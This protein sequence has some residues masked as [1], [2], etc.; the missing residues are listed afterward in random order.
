MND[1]LKTHCTAWALDELGD[2]DRVTLEQTLR[3]D[4]E[5]RTY[6]EETKDFCALLSTTLATAPDTALTE[7][8]RSGLTVAFSSEAAAP[9]PKVA[10]FRLAPVAWMVGLGGAAAALAVWSSQQAPFAKQPTVAANDSRAARE[11]LGERFGKDSR[12][13]DEVVVRAKESDALGVATDAPAVS[14]PMAEAEPASAP[15]VDDLKTDANVAAAAKEPVPELRQSGLNRMQAEAA[16]ASQPAYKELP[17]EASKPLAG[18]IE[19]AQ[20][21][22]DLAPAAAPPPPMPTTPMPARGLGRGDAGLGGMG[23]GGLEKSRAGVH[24]ADGEAGEGRYR[25]VEEPKAQ[26][27]GDDARRRT[28]PATRTAELYEEL[29]ENPF[30]AVAAAP[31]STFSID[32]DTASYANVRRFLNQGQRPPKAAVRTEELVNYFTYD[33]PQPEAGKPFSVT[34]DMTEAPWQPKHRLARIGLKGRE[35]PAAERPACNLV[36]LLDVSG[37]MDE[38]D[39][40]PLVKQ[41]LR[42]VTGQLTERDRVSLVTY[43][44]ESGVA[45]PSTPA[46]DKARITA[47]I[48]ALRAG[49][50]TNGASGIRLAYDQAAAHFTKEGVNRVIIATDGDFNVG[51]TSR[52]ALQQLITEQAKRGIFL[53]VLGYGTGNLKDATMEMLADKGN[54]NY[55]YIDSLSE[56][57]KVLGEQMNAT[58]VTIAKDVK[59]Q[60]EFNPAVVSSYRL[61]GYEN[62]V[63]A[64]EDFN[65]DRKDAGEIGAG[66]TVTALY[67]IVPVGVQPPAPP[68]DPLK[69]QQPTEPQPQVA[70]NKPAAPAS[71]ET[72]T[73][74]L[75]WKAPD[76]DVSQLAEMGVVDKEAKLAEAPADAKF[77]A[78]VAA[79]GLLLKDSAHKGTADWDM[80]R[81]LAL[82]GKGPDALGYRGE[83]IQLVDKAR[84]VA[85]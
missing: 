43:A 29:P 45:L 70:D 39:K 72:L 9:T 37:S 28:T 47:S 36:F 69:Y 75:R 6:A 62:R 54:G 49:G 8:Q 31:L 82:E 85:P 23:G 74:K 15:A 68:V 19:T 73:V 64:K 65:D 13:E 52:E 59:I 40:L 56:A 61:L 21:L 26:E 50:S 63:L 60:I 81:R 79:F 11:A 10:R 78:G 18:R 2:Q 83:F 46:S 25:R 58:L 12:R 41:S 24:L 17:E 20:E 7:E 53:S 80:V 76:G 27:F 5:A 67:E 32:V 4:A 55:G 35:I 1:Q 38:P 30:S 48:D 22:S 44:G 33:Y 3:A 71:N 42:F 51:V 84:S 66:H 16:S 14:A 34:V 77:A 57:R